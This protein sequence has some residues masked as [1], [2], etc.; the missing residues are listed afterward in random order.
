MDNELFHVHTKG[1]PGHQGLVTPPRPAPKIQEKG[2]GPE[3]FMLPPGDQPC[4]S[5]TRPG[6]ANPLFTLIP[7]SSSALASQESKQ[8]SPPEMATA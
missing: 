5:P 3:S 6:S 4:S 1:H 2:C 7:P 8:P